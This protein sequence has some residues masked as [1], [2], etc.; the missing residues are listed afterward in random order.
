MQVMK[1]RTRIKYLSTKEIMLIFAI[2]FIS[3]ITSFIILTDSDRPLHF[4][5]LPLLPICFGLINIFFFSI[6]R[7]IFEKIS[8]LL[9]I[10]LYMV[11]NVFTP[12]V[13]SFGGYEGF[14]TLLYPDNVNKAI[15]LM[16]YE[17]FIV[18]ST[19]YWLRD[20]KFKKATNNNKNNS[21]STKKIR[22]FGTAIIL[23]ILVN[24]FAYF[25]VPQISSN[26]SSIFLGE[27]VIGD[28]SIVETLPTG[29]IHRILYT[30]FTF[31]F[32]FLQ[33]FLCVWLII[34]IRKRMGD[35]KLGVLLSIVIIFANF[36]FISNETAYTF[37]VVFA[38]LI[39]L[40]K[41]FPKNKVNIKILLIVIFVVPL[42]YIYSYKSNVASTLTNNDKFSTASMMLQ[43][44]FPGISNLAGVFNVVNFE[45][46][47][48]LFHDIYSM[49]PFRN[50]VFGLEDG[51]RLVE[52]Y[53]RQNDALYQIIPSIGQA[54][55]YLGFI[56]AP[57]ISVFFVYISVRAENYLKNVNNIWKFIT[58]L[59]L[60]IYA[61]ATPILYGPTIF[62][63]RFF[64]TLLPMLI[65]SKYSN[66]NN[67]FNNRREQN[68]T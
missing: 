63:A 57:I 36:L 13:M 16:I 21:T 51:E 50:T 31:S 8:Y 49:I 5:W 58:Y 4:E 59:L 26:Y 40:L 62:G 19:L 66:D 1:I 39:L 55:H 10:S 7:N 45:K 34:R 47:S 44:Y 37:I 20:K 22:I 60:L 42:I 38:L 30:L 68:V 53:T 17:T 48:T 15:A 27:Q 18:F 14:F 61:A 52:V 23:L 43:A 28:R 24:V 2:L 46:L 56:F 9:I 12:L 54:Y 32:N 25:Q 33:V 6:F 64:N 35:T 11:R 29:S 67:L 41:I 3:I 65:L